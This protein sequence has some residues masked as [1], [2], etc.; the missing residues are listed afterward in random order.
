[1]PEKTAQKQGI[2]ESLFKAGAHY[3]FARSRRHPSVIPYVFGTKNRVEIFDLTET[4]KLLTA[5]KEFAETLGK[6][7]KTLLFVSGKPE[8]REAIAKAATSLNQPY[9]ASRRIGGTIPNMN[10]IK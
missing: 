10:K 5:A 7:G 8:A 9:V 2:I 1:M 3:G 6:E 4:E